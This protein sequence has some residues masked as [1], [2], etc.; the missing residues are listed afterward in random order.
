MISAC[1]RPATESDCTKIVDKS[2]ELQLKKMNRPPD[3][4]A[5]VKADTVAKMKDRITQCIG[6]RITDRM[7]SCVDT[8]E[9]P[10]EIDH[11]MK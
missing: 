2:I 10:D 1:G 8:S 7:M 3:E 9:T 11:C 6:K 5:K 4:I